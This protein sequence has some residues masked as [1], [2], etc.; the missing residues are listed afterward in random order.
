M[1]LGGTLP[2]NTCLCLFVGLMLA[3]G[4]QHARQT[5]YWTR[6]YIRDESGNTIAI[7]TPRPTD[8][9]PPS[10]PSS[11]QVTATGTDSVSLLWSAVTDSTGSG[12]GGYTIYRGA[13]P[14][15]TV[16][17]S[18]TSFIDKGLTP[19]TDF[20][21]KVAAFDNARNYSAFSPTAS[22]TTLDTAH[23]P[24]S[25]TAIAVSTTQVSVTWQAPTSGPPDHYS[26]HRRSNGDWSQLGTTAATT[27]SDTTATSGQ[28]Y[29][30]RVAAETSSNVTMGNSRPDIAT[31]L[32]FTDGTLTAGSTEIKGVHISELRAAAS[33]LREIAG[34]EP[35]VWTD[36]NLTGASVKAVHIYELR[37][38]LGDAINRLGLPVP[39]YTDSVLIGATVKAIHITQL[40]QQIQ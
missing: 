16:G 22:G 12:L 19:I 26:V 23:I 34:L 21:Y 9:T 28:I 11:L 7:A 8:T 24:R 32:A 30:Y 20:T 18:A 6:D 4:V 15:G 17:P 14:V 33:I 13:I 3:A 27:F 36:S 1:M 29:L 25:V 37:T 31:T 38:A 5:V 35:A 2:R 10:A 39:G 40:R